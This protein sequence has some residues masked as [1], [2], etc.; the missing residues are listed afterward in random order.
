MS[1]SDED[2]KDMLLEAREYGTSG[3]LH[4]ITAVLRL[5]TGESKILAFQGGTQPVPEDKMR[6]LVAKAGLFLNPG[7]KVFLK[8]GT[9]TFSLKPGVRSSGVHEDEIY[10][11]EETR[12]WETQST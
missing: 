10:V 12:P 7:E 4:V 2:I 9:A 5:P 1:L 6:D 3:C 8:H 11:W